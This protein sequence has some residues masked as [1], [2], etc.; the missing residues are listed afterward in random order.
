MKNKQSPL[1]VMDNTFKLGLVMVAL[2][3]ILGV[4]AT[5]IIQGNYSINLLGVESNRVGD[6]TS[7]KVRLKAVG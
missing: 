2:M 6:A 5:V 7:V 1:A 3:F 4:L